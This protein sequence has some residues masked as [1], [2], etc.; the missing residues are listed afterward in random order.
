MS[1]GAGLLLL[2]LVSFLFAP[3]VFANNDSAGP[4]AS[5]PPSAEQK[6]VQD[7]LHGHTIVDPYRWLEEASSPETQK[8][9][10]NQLAYTRGLIDPLPE[11]NAIHQRLTELLSIG[12]ISAP[13]IGG[14]FYLYTKREGSQN[15]PVLF[16]REGLQGKDRALVD[17]N[18]LAPDGTVA[19]DWWQ[20]SEDGKYVAYGTSPSGSEISALRV[21]ETET[22]KLLAD[23]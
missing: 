6:P 10:A 12:V 1:E 17:V 7:V 8:W 11:R 4:A 2:V 21:I 15:Q 22:G 5:G 20:A 23:A 3:A 14:K 18:A 9:T 16:V 13:Q 19:L